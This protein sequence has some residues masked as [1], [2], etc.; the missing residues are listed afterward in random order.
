MTLKFAMESLCV[1]CHHG[2]RPA[3]QLGRGPRETK[4]TKSQIEG[5]IINQAEGSLAPREYLLNK[6]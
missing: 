4:G 3:S 5:D 1:S 6:V 2:E